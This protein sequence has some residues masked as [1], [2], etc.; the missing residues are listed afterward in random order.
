MI[1][2]PEGALPR[3]SARPLPPHRHE[4]G[5]PGAPA[6]ARP[7]GWEP[8]ADFEWACDLFD[9]RHLWEA[10]EVWELEWKT[11][12]RGSVD[13]DLLQGLICAA[14]FALKRHQGLRDAA[15]RLRA[16]SDELLGRVRAARGP[17]ARGIALDVLSDAL[18][19]FD[20]GGPWPR[21]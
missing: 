3:R 16:R 5:L 11:L 21:L 15:T 17:R 1:P 9:H 20:E 6:P 7:E 13:A 19:R 8:V 14:A 12:P 2:A 18:R 10:H 4:P